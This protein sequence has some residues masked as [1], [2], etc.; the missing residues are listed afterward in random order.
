MILKDNE[1]KSIMGGSKVA[2]A[3]G[4][5]LGAVVSFVLGLIDGYNNP[6]ACNVR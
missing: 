3:I 4:I 1:A 5:A 2:V 6:K